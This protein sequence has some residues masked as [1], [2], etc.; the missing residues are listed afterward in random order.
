LKD[1]SFFAVVGSLRKAV[2]LSIPSEK[3]LKKWVEGVRCENLSDPGTTVRPFN[4]SL[5]DWAE[6]RLEA[7]WASRPWFNVS[8]ITGTNVPGSGKFMKVNSERQKVG[9]R[10]VSTQYLE[11]KSLVAAFNFSIST[12]P[13]F[14]WQFLDD[15]EAPSR[16]GEGFEDSEAVIGSIQNLITKKLESPMLQDEA[17]M[18]H[19]FIPDE[20]YA[21][22]CDFID[23]RLGF[24]HSVGNIGFLEQEGGKLRTVANPNRLVQ[25][26]NVPLGV[27]LSDLQR[28]NV[29]CFVYNQEDGM[30]WAQ[31]AL[32]K[33]ISL[34][35]FD[36]SS[37]TDRLDY[38][39]WINCRFKYLEQQPERWPLLSRSLD[40][41]RDTASAPWSISGHVADLIGSPVNEISWSVGQPLGLR[42]SFPML[43]L[44][45][46]DFAQKAIVEVDGYFSTDHFACVGDDL[47][48]ESKYAD[49]Y[50]RVVQAFNGK[51]NNDKAM[52]SD[53][54]AEFCSHLVT[55]S[56]IYP[57][58]PKWALD[59]DGSTQN[60]EKFTTSGLKPQVPTWVY[61]V[62]NDI[63][64][65]HLDGFRSIPYSVSSNPLSL[66][67][68]LATNTLIAS[69][70]PGL[71]DRDYVTLQT[72][73]TRALQSGDSKLV[74]V[75]DL[76][77]SW[78]S[79]AYPHFGG[80]TTDLE[81]HDVYQALQMDVEDEFGS[82]S[83]DYST[84]VEVPVKQDWDY[85][86]NQY[87]KPSSKVN[88]DKRLAR[89]LSRVEYSEEN[90]LL[91]ASIVRKGVKTSVLVDTLPEIPQALITHHMKGDEGPIESVQ[92]IVLAPEAADLFIRRRPANEQFIDPL[93]LEDDYLD[94]C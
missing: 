31:E 61:N 30:K 28:R 15:I 91:E 36:M 60:V 89:E 42:P 54:Y 76:N 52:V 32:R 77:S 46:A 44:M 49:A 13:L 40:L 9:K 63:A 58:K 2:E 73:Y 35:S 83:T 22:T 14:I 45:N 56:S 55:R 78:S 34:S 47:I 24:S 90:G 92:D 51:I 94:L 67:R 81:I 23:H 18:G 75:K 25:W 66:N 21:A 65:F 57:L 64:K 82:V 33:G 17:L 38:S 4:E 93:V 74:L 70:H 41:F 16:M 53:K 10:W 86:E 48:I 72:L 43:T 26:A 37:A 62:H 85:R 59:I 11:P 68:R 12:A 20:E 84:S 8:D 88:S 1:K 87:K 19:S 29:D 6:H 71:R 5:L 69:Y 79:G 39:K 50:M 3:Q 27:V 80:D 7:E